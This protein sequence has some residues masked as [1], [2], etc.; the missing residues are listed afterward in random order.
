MYIV[1][2]FQVTINSSNSDD[3]SNQLKEM[4]V[5]SSVLVYT[6]IILASEMMERL[7]NQKDISQQVGT[8]IT[9]IF[10]TITIIC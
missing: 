4:T 5:D 7:T 6:D 10:T 8:T 3:V 2:T 9:I 1:L